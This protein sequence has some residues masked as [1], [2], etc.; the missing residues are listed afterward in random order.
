MFG[1][2]RKK[3]KIL[4]KL[5]GERAYR[6]FR[7]CSFR[8]K[9]AVVWQFGLILSLV[10][11]DEKGRGGGCVEGGGAKKYQSAVDRGGKVQ[12]MV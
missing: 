4:K 12:L 8:L 2:R 9:P 7:S 6:F 3:K 10:K 5:P 1:G 11:L